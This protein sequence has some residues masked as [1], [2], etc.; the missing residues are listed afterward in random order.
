[1]D[2][3][4][5]PRVRSCNCHPG[6]R[7]SLRCSET[8]IFWKLLQEFAYHSEYEDPFAVELANPFRLG[9]WACVASGRTHTG[10]PINGFRHYCVGLGEIVE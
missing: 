1:M 10:G 3:G 6:S 5:G 8:P 4:P 7:H 2:I 9:W